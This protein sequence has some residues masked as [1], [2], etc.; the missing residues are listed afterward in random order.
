MDLHNLHRPTPSSA[1]QRQNPPASEIQHTAD[2]LRR[3]LE[4]ARAHVVHWKSETEKMDSIARDA[5]DKLDAK[6]AAKRALKVE[7]EAWKGRYKELSETRMSSQTAHRELEQART[8]MQHQDDTIKDLKSVIKDLSKK[9]GQPHAL[10]EELR[11]ARQV[12]QQHEAERE[13]LKERLQIGG[14][15]YRKLQALEPK[16]AASERLAQEHAASQKRSRELEP[17]L[18]ASEARA[19]SLEAELTALKTQAVARTRQADLDAAKARQAESELAS[20]REKLRAATHDASAT[21][22]RSQACRDMLARAEQV[23]ATCSQLHASKGDPL[24]KALQETT[25][26]IAGFLAQQGA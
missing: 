7:L 25:A 23:L 15:A 13:G 2:D 24:A 17:K 16:L 19:R 20:A 22:A 26:T 12:I 10:E 5:L 18:A 8:T 21:A 14:E 1:Q 9:A 4:K 6:R 11:K 3:D